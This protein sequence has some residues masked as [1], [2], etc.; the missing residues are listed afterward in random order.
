MNIQQQQDRRPEK[1]KY[2]IPIQSLQYCKTENR[3]QSSVIT[4][5][6]KEH[7]RANHIQ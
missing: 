2:Q 6:K 7:P 1:N 4:R 3:K 5:L